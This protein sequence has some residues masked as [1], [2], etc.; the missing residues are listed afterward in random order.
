MIFSEEVIESGRGSLIITCMRPSNDL[1]TDD[2]DEIDFMPK[3]EVERGIAA[4]LAEEI[5]EAIEY[6]QTCSEVILSLVDMKEL[7][8]DA[9]A[10]DSEMPDSQSGWERLWLAISEAAERGAQAYNI[11][12]IS[13]SK[14]SSA[15][16]IEPLNFPKLFRSLSSM[17][18][19]HYINHTVLIGLDCRSDET[20]EDV[21]AY[22]V[23]G[24][25]DS[26]ATWKIT[27]DLHLMALSSE[28]NTIIRALVF[29][30]SK[31]KAS[32]RLIE[33]IEAKLSSES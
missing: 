1:S 33:T 30:N 2:F 21:I 16:D 18:A 12:M 26:M 32:A 14:H 23:T 31:N 28:N 17:Q 22:L 3:V 27:N 20:E 19:P 13:N 6:D 9:M 8:Q 4:T 24:D 11:A 5:A 7:I 10:E 25:E 29:E 15:E